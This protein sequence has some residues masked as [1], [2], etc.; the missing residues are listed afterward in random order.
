MRP[1]HRS[2]FTLAT[3]I[4]VI[5]AKHSETVQKPDHDDIN[6][7]LPESHKTACWGHEKKSCG[8]KYTDTTVCALTERTKHWVKD[9]PQDRKLEGVYEKWD[10]YVDFGYVKKKRT[11]LTNVTNGLQC[12]HHL[13]MCRGN[14]MY[15]EFGTMG[16]GGVYRTDVVK[17][18]A[19]ICRHEDDAECDKKKILNKQFISDNSDHI[20]ALQ[21]WGS[22]MKDLTSIRIK[23]GKK[24]K[25]DRT[26]K[27]DV[28]FIKIDAGINMYHHFCDFVNLY[29]TQ[30]L[31]GEFTQDV[32]IVIWQT[33]GRYWSYFMDMMK[34]FSKHPTIHLTEFSDKKICFKGKV[35]FP[36]L[37]R[38]RYGLFYN[39]PLVP[40]CQGSGLFRAFSEHVKHRFNFPL[41]LPENGKCKVTFLSRGTWK[42]DG[43]AYGRLVSNEDEM[44]N[45]AKRFFPRCKFTKVQFTREVP[46]LS[47][48]K[49][50]SE[51][52][53]FVGMH[54]AG[55]THLLFLPDTSKVIELYN[56]EDRGCYRDLAYLRGIPYYTWTDSFND[57]EIPPKKMGPQLNPQYV[58][59]KITV[60][61]YKKHAK[62]PENQKF[63][64]FEFD[65]DQWVELLKL[66]I[67]EHYKD[68]RAN[69]VEKN[70]L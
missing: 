13:R 66:A 42:P 48:M 58:P 2:P 22:E 37:S 56:C 52:T 41:A 40:H 5:L 60:T 59:P 55:L 7:P 20:G 27:K 12:V 47:Q 24:P 36:H 63:W 4:P 68:P 57:S 35:T 34:V 43:G 65:L 18:I 23:P 10:E 14:D 69:K 26:I 17:K 25:C 45:Y 19:T 8:T 32:Q 50:I 9:Y 6:N 21:S 39:T 51:S 11:Q 44:L 1:L 61:D 46:F 70:E 62:Y 30:H 16:N 29:L 33:Q 64:N 31:V 28:I 54:G 53:L 38:Q 49:I 3:F 15:M 67:P